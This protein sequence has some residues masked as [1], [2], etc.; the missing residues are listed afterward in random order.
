MEPKIANKTIKDLRVFDPFPAL[1][2][3][4]DSIKLDELEKMI[5]H[6]VPYAVLLVKAVK[7][8]KADHDGVMPKNWA[9]KCQFKETIKSLQA[10]PNEVNFEEA[11]NSSP[12]AYKTHA[13][14]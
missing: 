10:F 2:Q 13:L 7:K 4:A 6:H 8:W 9:E 3:F 1:E 5:H 11:C 14:E 12:D